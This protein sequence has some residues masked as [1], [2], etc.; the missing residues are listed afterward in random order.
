MVSNLKR[1]GYTTVAMHPYYRTGWRRNTVYP[2]LGFDEMHFMDDG[3]NYFDVTNVMRD[4]ITDEEMFDKI[5]R[6]FEEKGDDPMFLMGITMQNHG[7]YNATVPDVDVTVEPTSELLQLSQ[8]REFL[9]LAKA[10]DRA[11]EELIRYYE[12]VEENTIILMFGDHQPGMDEAVYKKLNP[13][14]YEDGAP[15]LEIQKKYTVPYVIWANYDL[16]D[17]SSEESKEA[18]Q[19]S[20]SAMGET[21]AAYVKDEELPLTSP[22]YLGTYLLRNAGL[23]LNEWNLLNEE[24]RTLYPAVNVK[25]Y[26][27]ADGIWHE[28][29]EMSEEPLLQQYKK[30]AYLNLFDHSKMDASY[31]D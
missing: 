27:D 22:G 2:K 9:S 28:P 26:L 1:Q 4:Y 30:A 13:A 12:Q 20:L 24:S 21:Q 14:M 17:L 23:S 25:G 15:L 6:C 19:K 29:E 11:F 10:S 16:P 3:D 7:G 31:F 5:I 18:A 8:L